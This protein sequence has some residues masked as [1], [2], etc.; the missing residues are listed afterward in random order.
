M[1]P[2]FFSDPPIRSRL[3]SDKRVTTD[4]TGCFWREGCRDDHIAT[5]GG[6]EWFPVES[7]PTVKEATGPLDQRQEI[8]TREGTV[9]AEPGDYLIRED[10]G[11][12]YPIS[13][14]KFGRYY[15]RIETDGGLNAETAWSSTSTKMDP[16]RTKEADDD[17]DA[18]EGGDP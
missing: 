11:N 4:G 8:E 10:D 1:R 9:F 14:D 16:T 2:S 5:D 13:D 3:P 12:V 7:T 18:S 15:R 6:R 17:V